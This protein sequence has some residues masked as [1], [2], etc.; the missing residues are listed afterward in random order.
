MNKHPLTDLP[1]V[2]IR[3]WA[4]LLN[5]SN[6]LLEELQEPAYTNRHSKYDY[7]AYVKL[8]RRNQYATSHDLAD[9]ARS[10]HPALCH[11]ENLENDLTETLGQRWIDNQWQNWLDEECAYLKHDWLNGVSH[12]VPQYWSSLKAEINRD[13]NCKTNYPSVDKL[14]SKQ[15]KL[16]KLEQF[17]ID[18]A[19]WLDAFSLIDNSSAGF[20]GRCGG[21]FCFNRSFS[22]SELEEA[23]E[24]MTQLL[25]NYKD[26]HDLNFHQTLALYRDIEHQHNTCKA[27]CREIESMAKALD[28]HH[29]LRTELEEAFE[30]SLAEI[31]TSW[32]QGAVA[33]KRLIEQFADTVVTIKDAIS[34][35]NCEQGTRNWMRITLP[36]QETSTI[37]RLYLLAKDGCPQATAVF[38]V[39][40]HK[41]KSLQANQD[42]SASLPATS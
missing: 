41:I 31:I 37:S 29:Y 13:P 38:R 32:T 33:I 24:E 21:H 16:R 20:E 28:F 12:A 9:I 10:I 35:G 26:H 4:Q 17:K 15:A 23:V 3:N 25:A 14:R 27:V 11:R 30:T 18:D 6:A 2:R 34:A 1:K 5:A 19:L 42:Q 40:F 22:Y 36:G 39:I 7:E 8:H